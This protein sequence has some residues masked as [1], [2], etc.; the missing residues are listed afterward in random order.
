MMDD[1]PP[2]KLY[3]NI[4]RKI[5]SRYIGDLLFGVTI[6]NYYGLAVL[7]NRFPPGPEFVASVNEIARFLLRSA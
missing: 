6:T 1:L 3:G 7:A 2:S 4:L 5:P